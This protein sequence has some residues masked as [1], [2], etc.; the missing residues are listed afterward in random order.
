M[1][2]FETDKTQEYYSLKPKTVNF[3]KGLKPIIATKTKPLQKHYKRGHYTRY[4][5]KRNN[6]NNVYFEIDI[7]TFKALKAEN[8]KYDHNLYTAGSLNWAIDGDI[9][10]TNRNILLQKE[11]KFI[12]ISILFPKLNEFQKIRKT[13]GGELEYLNGEN[14]IGYYHLH[15]SKP[16]EGLFHSSKNQKTLK[17]LKLPNQTISTPNESTEYIAPKIVQSKIIDSYQGED[18]DVPPPID[19]YDPPTSSPSSTRGGSLGG[20]S[21]GGG[22]G[23]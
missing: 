17:Y 8:G 14:Y 20:S 9:M 22:G 2:I 23:Y 7:K 11:K 4:F 16:M 19:D 6:A 21:G 5:C 13:K 18:V 3:L 15:L 1:P 12:N 10:V